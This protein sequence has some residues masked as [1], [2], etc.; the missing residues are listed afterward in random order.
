MKIKVIRNGLFCTEDGEFA[1]QHAAALRAHY[2]ISRDALVVGG[3]FRFYPEKQPLIWLEAAG[4][5]AEMQPNIHFMLF[6][7]GLMRAAMIEKVRMLGLEN[8]FHFC[9][10][11]SPATY[12]LSA[13]NLVL[14]TSVG[15]GTPNVLLEAQSLGLP[16]VTTDAGGAPEAVLDGVT[17]YVMRKGGPEEIADAVLRILQDPEFCTAVR[18]HGPVFIEERYGM[19]RM[20]EETLRLY[21]HHD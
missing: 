4:R 20:I 15:E 2:G 19:D 8:R 1:A 16:V 7:D 3:M 10:V 11:V 6:G 13:C 18:R 21:R 12:A 17:G 9:G 14:L 5:V